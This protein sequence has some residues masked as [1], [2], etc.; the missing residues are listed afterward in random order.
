MTT[1]AKKHNDHLLGYLDGEMSQPEHETFL[2]TLSENER[3]ELLATESALQALGRL[4]QIT[5]PASLAANVM[6]AIRP[7]RLPLLTRLRGWLERHPLLGW[8]VSGM[9]LAASLLFMTLAPTGSL[10]FQPV[11]PGQEPFISV[12][13][14]SGAAQAERARFSLY[15][16]QAHSISLIGEFNGWGSEQQLSLR[17]QGNGVWTVEVPLSPGRYQYAFLIDG[18]DMATDPRAEQRVNDDFGRKNAVLTVM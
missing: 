10:P 11:V 6:A 18:K 14:T 2:A 12:A 3:R 15:A 13:A 8:E 1:L 17:P 5:A 7:K 4:P 16:P 9:A